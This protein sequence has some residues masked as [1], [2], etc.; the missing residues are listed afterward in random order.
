MVL[1]PSAAVSFGNFLET[2]ILPPTSD[3]VSQKLWGSFGHPARC[4]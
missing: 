2:K 1:G 3:L 4:F